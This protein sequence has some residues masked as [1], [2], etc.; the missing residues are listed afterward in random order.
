MT[1]LAFGQRQRYTLYTV[2]SITKYLSFQI[3]MNNILANLILDNVFFILCF[4]SNY[5]LEVC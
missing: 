2:L 4:S 3:N 5:C 1:L